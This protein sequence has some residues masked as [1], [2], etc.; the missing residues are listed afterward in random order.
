MPYTITAEGEKDRVGYATR[1]DAIAA[2]I[3]TA[4]LTSLR[5]NVDFEGSF[6]PD[7]ERCEVRIYDRSG[8]Q[9]VWTITCD[10]P[11]L[12]LESRVKELEARLRNQESELK[13]LKADKEERRDKKKKRKS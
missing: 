4:P 12:D 3:R 6:T 8:A 11:V 1:T 5:A 7:T 9:K 13:A 10:P 2:V